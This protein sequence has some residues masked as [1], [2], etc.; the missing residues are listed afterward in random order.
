V[1]HVCGLLHATTTNAP[2]ESD[3]LAML[4]VLAQWQRRPRVTVEIFADAAG[5]EAFSAAYPRLT[6][7][8]ASG[9]KQASHGR[10][11]MVMCSS[12]RF[13]DLM[14]A[15]R[16]KITLR[17][18]RIAVY[19]PTLARKDHMRLN[20]AARFTDF[21]WVD[22]DAVGEAL[23]AQGIPRTRI[24]FAHAEHNAV[25]SEPV[26][27][28]PTRFDAIYVGPRSL[29]AATDVLFE[30]WRIVCTRLLKP[31]LILSGYDEPGFDSRARIDHAGISA[32]IDFVD[33]M[34]DAQIVTLLAR[35]RTVILPDREQ[36]DGRI[37]LEALTHGVP[38]ITFDLPSLRYAFPWGRLIA[39][40]STPDALAEKIVELL[41]NERIPRNLIDDVTA[42]FQ[43]K[44]W[45]NVADVLW[46]RSF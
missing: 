9:K 3:S 14:P 7:R 5:C 2:F 24:D 30:A 12:P 43:P 34:N 21:F 1:I 23:V 16:L 31:R 6:F 25:A 20:I 33:K 26:P 19:V 44:R 42:H 41:E 46:S 11:D 36:A 15:L 8:V 13:A 35:A 22:D 29:P 18:R 40:P 4:E 17:A 39:T 10:F 32:S 37:I 38:C 45:D 27:N 28:A